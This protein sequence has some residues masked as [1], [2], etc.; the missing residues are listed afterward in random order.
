M[1]LKN[2][3]K[4]WGLLALLVLLGSGCS[5]VTI[6][7]DSPPEAQYAEGE[8]LLKR[9]RY[10]EAVERFRILKNRHPY[11]VYAALAALR[12]GDVYFTQESFIEAAASYK[13]FLELY[14]K[15]PQVDYAV[16]RL[17][18]SFYKQVPDE[19]DRDLSAAD[20]GITAF[21]RLEQEFPQS[22]HLAQS[23]KLRKELKERLAA[24]EEYV[25]DYYFK[26]EDWNAAAGRYRNILK[27][28]SDMG[29][30]E[31]ALFRLAFAYEKVGEKERSVEAIERLESDFP[32][33]KFA[34]DAAELKL[35]L[36]L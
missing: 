22:S 21:G 16:F 17:G 32:Q 15:H 10:L 27:D 4:L 9:N 35:R 25:A 7:D 28:F 36:A 20:E 6:E 1:R 26:R 5:S 34:K 13:V 3:I 30:N 12:M 23:Q 18:E 14:P 31:K 2:P 33:G 11:S 8:R 29:R 19:I 24:R